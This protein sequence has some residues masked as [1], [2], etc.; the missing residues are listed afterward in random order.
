MSSGREYKLQSASLREGLVPPSTTHYISHYILFWITTS[1]APKVWDTTALPAPFQE[2]LRKNCS[3]FSLSRIANFLFQDF[4]VII[5]YILFF[6]ISNRFAHGWKKNVHSHTQIWNSKSINTVTTQH[7]YQ[8]P[9][10]TLS[11]GSMP[12]LYLES[13]CYCYLFV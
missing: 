7:S 4:S 2:F 3:S 6:A 13:C 10:R 12:G 8:L 11:S 9:S 5:S 1:L